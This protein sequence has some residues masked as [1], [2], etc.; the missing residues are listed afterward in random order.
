MAFVSRAE[1][2]TN[3]KGTASLGPGAYIGHAEYKKRENY[4]PFCSSTDRGNSLASQYTPG[5]GSYSTPN[6]LGKVNDPGA[7]NLSEI[8]GSQA[9]RATKYDNFKLT[10]SK[11]SNAFASKV[12]RFNRKE[13]KNTLPGPGS[14]NTGE[15]WVKAKAIKSKSEWQSV[16][17]MRLPSAPSIPNNNQ[18]FGYEESPN[19]ELIMQKN[20]EKVFAG[21]KGDSIGPGHY[22]PND[23]VLVKTAP[24]TGWATSKAKRMQFDKK[25]STQ[26]GPGSYSDSKIDIAPMY[27]FKQSSIFASKTNRFHDEHKG[28][29]KKD[30]PASEEVSE[31]EDSEEEVDDVTP[32]P[33]YYYDPRKASSFSLRQNP[34]HLQFFG[35]TSDRFKTFDKSTVQQASIGPGSYGSIQTSMVNSKKMTLGKAPFMSKGDRFKK[36]GA[37]SPGPGN[38]SDKTNLA[39]DVRRKMHG[40]QGVFGSTE[41]RFVQPKSGIGNAMIGPGSYNSVVKKEVYATHFSKPS[42]VFESA[43]KRNLSVDAKKS[44]TP[45]PGSYNVGVNAFNDKRYQ[46]AG[47]GNPLMSN[48]LNQRPV[49][50]F[51][52]KSKRFDAERKEEYVQNVG[53]GSYNAK[54]DTSKPQ[55]KKEGF[56][57]KAPRFTGK[58]GPRDD[59][60]GPGQYHEEDDRWNKRTFNIIFAE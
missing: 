24:A 50:S 7:T 43:T 15:A 20:P 27:K 35:S 19:G 49:A 33:G 12:E 18:A 11:A 32:G 2:G 52:T 53:P 10:Q 23:R 42:A 51:N 8:T 34:E 57:S 14:Y 4:A 26:I 28:R 22:T 3:H 47:T 9:F 17:W 6:L 13:S 25:E 31:D 5:P 36:K 1:R 41:R 54:V 40:K 46:K 55:S 37:N 16:N 58:K 29:H 44:Q 56:I 39:E 21:G 45:A 59:K 38:Y 48:L 30:I 60:P